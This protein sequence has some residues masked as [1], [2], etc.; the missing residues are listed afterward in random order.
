MEGCYVRTTAEIC[1]GVISGVAFTRP[2]DMRTGYDE[3]SIDL[4][5]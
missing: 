5:K 2:V 1:I 4:L 3:L